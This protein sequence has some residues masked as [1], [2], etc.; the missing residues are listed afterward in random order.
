[1]RPITQAEQARWQ[2]VAAVALTEILDKHRDLPIIDWQ[3]H[4]T[5]RLFGMIPLG[6]L[7]PLGS[8]E[9][10]R[11]ALALGDETTLRDTVTDKH[12]VTGTWTSGNGDCVEVMLHTTVLLPE[13]EEVR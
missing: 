12:W 6:D 3:L 4:G 9:T 8:F 10:W 5:L 7:D 11:D 2:R 13:G 1:M